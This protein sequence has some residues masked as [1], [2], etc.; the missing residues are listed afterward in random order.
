MSGPDPT[1]HRAVAK[2]ELL[3]IL[4]VV[5][6]A[7]ESLRIVGAVVAGIINGVNAHAGLGGQQGVIGGAMETAANFSDG[8]G[9][10]LLLLSLAMIWWRAEH[11]SGRLRVTLAA[12]NPDGGLPEEAAQLHRLRSLAR[13]VTILF[14]LACAGAVAYVVGN[15]LVVSA[16]GTVAST[17][18]Q[19]YSLDS[20]SVAYLLIAVA[21]LIGALKLTKLCAAD[22]AQID[23]TT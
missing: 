13:W 3:E 5:I 14:A 9:I 19:A 10:V 2:W 21:G 23:A 20:F 1:V 18:W 22:V 15:V 6:L 12:S 16:H 17:R 11:W 4:A 7:A 8:P